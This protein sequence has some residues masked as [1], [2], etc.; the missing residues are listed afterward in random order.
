MRKS[1]EEASVLE[2][3]WGKT[4]GGTF[5]I[6]TYFPASSTL[7]SST[8]RTFNF[9]RLRPEVTVVQSH[10]RGGGRRRRDPRGGRRLV[11]LARVRGRRI[12]G[13]LVVEV[14]VVGQT[15]P[16]LRH[17]LDGKKRRV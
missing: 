13:Q 15:A 6:F 1:Q 17:W 10:D 9:A 3:L 8:C 16:F 5:Q 14:S 11:Q 7:F 2:S 12:L 4:I